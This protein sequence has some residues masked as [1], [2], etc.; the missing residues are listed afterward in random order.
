MAD[1]IIDI[2]SED[3]VLLGKTLKSQANKE[4]LW[5]KVIHLAIHNKKGEIL[6]QRRSREKRSFPG[7]WDVSVGGHIGTGEE[8]IDA[9]IRETEEELGIHLKK[10]ELEFIGSRKSKTITQFIKNFEI[11]YD[12]ISE[13]DI[14]INQLVLQKSE[15]EEAKFFPISWLKED[16]QKHPKNYVNPGQAWFDLLEIIE[17]RI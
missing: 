11:S 17:K 12:Y 15:V 7:L 3:G 6:L 8:P 16:L 14:D 4:G 5:H 2:Y 1:E 9:A 13:L 10:E